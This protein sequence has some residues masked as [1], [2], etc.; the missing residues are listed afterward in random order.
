MGTIKSWKSAL[1][2]ELHEAGSARRMD[3]KLAKRAKQRLAL[4][5]T[6]KGLDALNIPGWELHKWKGYT[7]KWSISISG[8]WRITWNWIN[9]EAHDVDLEQPHG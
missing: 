8:H 3:Q 5:D 6:A 1:L 4:L 2:Q 7:A 9:G